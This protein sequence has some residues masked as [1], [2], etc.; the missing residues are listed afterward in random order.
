VPCVAQFVSSMRLETSTL[1]LVIADDHQLML[2][3]LRAVFDDAEGFDVVA[4]ARNGS[5][6]IA[7]VCALRPDMLLLD[8]AMPTM[9]GFAVLGELR[10]REAGLMVVVLSGRDDELS[11]RRAIEAGAS[12]YVSKLLDPQDL[13]AVL[14]A[15]R[16]R[17]VATA[18]PGHDGERSQGVVFTERE[19]AV[20]AELVDGV[21][22]KVI[23]ARLGCSEQA[24]KYHLNHI[25]A[26]LAVPGRVE[27]VRALH[28]LRLGHA[29]PA[30]ATA[31]RVVA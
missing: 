2:E 17:L 19:R 16:D 8:L 1:R 4:A 22:N 27:A 18:P 30:R 3:A 25:Y 12:A 6:A 11:K 5:D 14:R 23:A 10:A 26:K 13:P 20:I 29:P 31:A 24:V 7:K 28:Q 15:V 21:A 9:D